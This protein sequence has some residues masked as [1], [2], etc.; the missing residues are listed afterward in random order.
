[1]VKSYKKKVKVKVGGE[2]EGEGGN[3]KQLQTYT[4]Y[5][6]HAPTISS[7]GKKI[8]HNSSRTI[9]WRR[10]NNSRTRTAAQKRYENYSKI[11]KFLTSQ[12]R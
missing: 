6:F 12:S 5:S 7:D 4:A 10:R 3:K 1:M 8:N 11:G 2:G 9:D